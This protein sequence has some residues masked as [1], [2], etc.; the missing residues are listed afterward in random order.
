VIHII[1]FTNVCGDYEDDNH[2]S[3]RF[4]FEEIT[5]S[6]ARLPDEVNFGHERFKCEAWEWIVYV[7]NRT[8][9]KYLFKWANSKLYVCV[10]YDSDVALD[11][12]RVS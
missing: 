7:K 11:N 9:V 3:S 2:D 10:W 12:I 4:R 1:Y 8:F 5:N 6:H